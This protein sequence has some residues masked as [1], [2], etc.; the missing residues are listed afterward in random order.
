MVG[1]S[2]PYT[3][4]LPEFGQAR[5]VQ[6]DIDPTMIGMRYPIEVNLVGDAA[7]DAAG[8]A[9]AAAPQ[10]GPRRG[11]RTSRTASRAG[12]RSWTRGR[13]VDAD[14]IN[15]HA[16]V[17]TSCRPRLPDDAIVTADSGS[18]ANWCA[19]HLRLRGAMRGSLSGTLATMGPGVPYAHRRQ[20][21]L[22]GP[23]R[24]RLV[25][26]GAMQMNGLA[27]LITI[28]QVLATGGRPAPG[29]RRAAQRRPQPGH[30]GAARHGGRPQVRGR[31]RRCPTS[32]Y[33]GLRPLDRLQRRRASTGPRR[34][35]RP[36]TQALAAEPAGRASRSD[37][38]PRGAAAAAAHHLRPGE[39]A[40]YALRARR[41]ATAAAIDPAGRQ[42]QGQEF[43]RSGHATIVRIGLVRADSSPRCRPAPRRRMLRNFRPAASSGR[44]PAHRGVRRWSIGRRDLPRALRGSFG[45]KWMWSPVV[46]APLVAAAGV[47][48]VLSQRGGAHRA[49]GARRR[50]M[51]P[52]VL[53][54]DC[55]PPARGPQQARRLLG[56]DATTS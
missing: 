32:P 56:G 7:R 45:N 15:P 36:G 10:G 46:L 50:C 31:R 38:R 18:A 39:G 26:D 9:P 27:E 53:I 5:A 49:A 21:R 44:C 12:G 28:A 52:T 55:T 11:A 8:A 3:Q 29:R 17:R 41:R 16:P 4:F 35:G 34:S 13:T 19:R 1:S 14:P 33:A 30:L 43:L 48:G 23:A 51:P 2:F 54:G 24:D 20:V 47:A 42:G 25:G 22:P 6:I 37:H 40:A